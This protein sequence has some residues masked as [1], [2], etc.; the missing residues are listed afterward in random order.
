MCSDQYYPTSKV[1]W[2]LEKWPACVNSSP[3]GESLER[4]RR[5]CPQKR[6]YGPKKGRHTLCQAR[7]VHQAPLFFNQQFCISCSRHVNKSRRRLC[8]SD[9]AWL[10]RFHCAAAVTFG[11]DNVAEN[12]EKIVNTNVNGKSSPTIPWL[13]IHK[14]HIVMA[15]YSWR[16]LGK[17]LRWCSWSQDFTINHGEQSH[18]SL[19][20]LSIKVELWI[21]VLGTSVASNLT[22]ILACN[23]HRLGLRE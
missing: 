14:F 23:E 1:Y 15:V 22:I 4:N 13:C 18:V 7:C 11:S 16:I 20:V 12:E 9:Y 3:S 19:E 17:V 6:S 10:C 5:W 21:W 8:Q 2:D